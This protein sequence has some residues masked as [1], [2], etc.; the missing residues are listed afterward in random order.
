LN[1]VELSP[2]DRAGF[3]DTQIEFGDGIFR[4]KSFGSHL[5][6][7]QSVSLIIWEFYITLCDAD[8]PLAVMQPPDT[9][10]AHLPTIVIRW[11]VGGGYDFPFNAVAVICQSKIDRYSK[12]LAKQSLVVYNTESGILAYPYFCLIPSS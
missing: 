11:T 10:D 4:N 1:L 6:L 12:F 9:V 7:I 3:P 5:R 8:R 2:I